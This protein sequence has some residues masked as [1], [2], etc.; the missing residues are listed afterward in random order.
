EHGPSGPIQQVTGLR[1]SADGKHLAW[2]RDAVDMF[3]FHV[4]V[5]A[6]AGKLEAD[7]DYLSPP[8]SFA[9]GYG[10]GPNATQSLFVLLWNQQVLV[11]HG[12]KSDALTCRATLRLPRGFSF[13][14]AL[15]I[16]TKDAER[17]E[18][19]PVSLTTL[20]DSPVL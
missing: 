2:R 8:E 9:S 17:I 1:I 19:A 18:F 13:D 11:P 10:N 20:V 14:T 5:P 16:A 6:G 15:P 3:A 7:F 4:V 12:T